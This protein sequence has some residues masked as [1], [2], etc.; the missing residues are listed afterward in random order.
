MSAV[1]R[2]HELAR[3]NAWAST[4]VGVPL[5][6]VEVWLMAV[7]LDGRSLAGVTTCAAAAVVT[8]SVVA[9]AWGRATAAARATR[10]G[11]RLKVG[12]RAAAGN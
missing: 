2:R 7:T 6:T 12:R 5:A 8:A 4:A 10:R 3:L 1:V 11:V 9:T